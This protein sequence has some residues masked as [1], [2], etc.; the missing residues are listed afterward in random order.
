MPAECAQWPQG[1]LAM[2]YDGTG[3][4]D[5]GTM[6]LAVRLLA[7]SKHTFKVARPSPKLNRV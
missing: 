6:R 7:P 3:Y 2:K 5:A 1:N 4:S